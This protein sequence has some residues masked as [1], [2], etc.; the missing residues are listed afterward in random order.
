[1]TS[2]KIWQLL[3]WPFA[4]ISEGKEC[5]LPVLDGNYVLTPESA[6]QNNFPENSEAF[7]ECSNGYERE[8]GSTSI[9]CTDGKWSDVELIC[10]KRDCGQPKPSPKMSY[11]IE[12]GTLFGEYIKPRCERGYFLE[13]SSYRQCLVN[14]WSGRSECT[15]ITCDPPIEIEN[16]KI[17]SY[18]EAPELD[19]VI[20]Y[21]C[22]ANYILAGNRYMKC[23]EDGEYDSHPP[24]CQD[25]KIQTKESI[26][27]NIDTTNSGLHE[28]VGEQPATYS[29][30]SV[31]M[32]SVVSGNLYFCFILFV[33]FF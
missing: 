15:L 3:L 28:R 26:T 10:K 27:T 7:L 29:Q 30:S 17:V 16:G 20:E 1:M 23:G 32:G 21:S 31:I 25:M 19:D 4:L 12:S 22:N 13:G 6:L 8:A 18:K 14:G 24:I 5:P 11:I 2:V 9:L 33:L